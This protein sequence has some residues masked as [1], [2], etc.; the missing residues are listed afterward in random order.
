MVWCNSHRLHVN[1]SKS[2][3]IFLDPRAIGDRMPVVIHYKN[4][5]QETTFKYLVGYIDSDLSWYTQV[6]SVC[7]RTHQ[8]PHFLHRLHLL[9]SVRKLG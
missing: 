6:S 2:V 7:A 5:K 9:E 3:E 8:H 4:I 1:T